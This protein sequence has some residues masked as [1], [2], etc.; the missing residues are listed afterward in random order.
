[1][2]IGG[3]LPLAGCGAGVSTAGVGGG[4]VGGGGVSPIGPIVD[5]NQDPTLISPKESN[6]GEPNDSFAQAVVAVFAGSRA[7]LEGTVS[8]RGDIDVY[9]LGA[10]SR[11]DR[12]TVDV[13]TDAVASLLDGAVSIHDGAQRLVYTNDDRMV[14][15]LDP[16]VQ[17]VVRDDSSAYYLVVSHSAFSANGRFEGAYLVDVTIESGLPVPPPQPQT[18]LLD[19]D[20][21]FVD[22]PTLGR[23]AID[24]FD[25]SRIARVYS[26]QSELIKEAIR[27]SVEENFKG[28]DVDVVTSDDGPVPDSSTVSTIFLGGFDAATFGI[29]ENVDL[30]NLDR[31]DDAIIYT[32]SF[33]PAQF[34]FVPDAASLAVAIGNVAAHEAGHLIGLNHVDDDAALMDD[35]SAADALLLDQRFMEAPMSTDIIPIGTQ[36]AVLLLTNIVGLR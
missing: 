33:S 17:W 21:G 11:G 6:S 24:P 26:G 35:R 19:F 5:G 30:Y 25:A 2:G 1:M 14:T 28:F 29:A 3:L 32:E 31:C 10:L 34:S 27:Q 8:Q 7:Q 18:L 20:G 16:F 13:D 12:I 22:S 15:D 36:D 23:V 4:S 9:L